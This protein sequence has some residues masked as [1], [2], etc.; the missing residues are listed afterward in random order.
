[1]QWRAEQMD[2]FGGR[3]TPGLTAPSVTPD[4]TA[5]PKILTAL[6]YHPYCP[7]KFLTAPQ[8]KCGKKI[9]QKKVTAPGKKKTSARPY[10]S[11]SESIY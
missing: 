11:I 6:P 9:F 10:L 3:I 1:M 7:G 4:L 8:V 5:P 2:G